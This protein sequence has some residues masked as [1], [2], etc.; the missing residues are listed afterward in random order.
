MT[1]G[2][3]KRKESLPVKPQELKKWIIVGKAKL[4][5]QIAAIKAISKLEEGMAAKEAALSDTQD[6]AEELLYAEARLGEMLADGNRSSGKRT[7]DGTF[8]G[9]ERLPPSIDKKQSHY[10]QELHSNE[11]VIAKV[12]AEA[13]EKGEIPVRHHVLKEIHGPHVS[14]NAGQ[15]EWYTPKEMIDSARKVM[16]SID[17]DPAT[18][19]DVNE[20]IVKSKTFFTAETNG[21]NKKW[22]GN[23]WMNPPYSQPAV[24]QFCNTFAQKYKDEEVKQGCVLINNVTETSFAQELLKLCSAV[25][26]PVGRVKFLDINGDPGAPLQGQM[27]IYFGQNIESFINEFSKFGL[28]LC[29]AR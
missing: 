21:L 11:D 9:R 4:Q 2:I 26:F 29:A 25:C 15:S 16:G 14:K 23:V 10:A 24:S 22:P 28:C 6:L 27:V 19:E 5:S 17:V 8:K 1:S 7:S 12:V 20:K 13:R 3:A 18:T